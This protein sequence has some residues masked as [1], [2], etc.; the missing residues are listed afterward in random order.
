MDFP[1]N[2]MQQGGSNP[3]SPFR[4]DPPATTMVL[5]PW[6]GDEPPTMDAILQAMAN[7]TGQ[8]LNVRVADESDAG[9]VWAC[10]VEIDGLP[11]PCAIWCD[12]SEELARATHEITGVQCDTLIAFETLLSVD[13]PLTNYINLVRLV[14]MTLPDSPVLHDTGSGYWLER[15]RILQD[16]MDVEREPS[17][18]ILWRIELEGGSVRTAGLQRCGREELVMFDVPEML[19]Q[20]AIE[21]ISDIAALSLELELPG[22]EGML[23]ISPDILVRFEPVTDDHGHTLVSVRDAVHEES[24]PCPRLALN[25]MN[26]GEIAVFRTT[27]RTRQTTKLAQTTWDQFIGAC[28]NDLH[29]EG[30]QFMVQ[31]PFEQVD[32][33]EALREHLWL[34]VVAVQD[35]AVEAKLAHRPRLVPGLD[36]G[37]TTMVA[38]DEV[39]NWTVHTED[40][41]IGPGDIDPEGEAA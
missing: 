27:R 10:Q 7:C 31:V 26:I 24:T 22:S 14:S 23:E 36:I 8:E 1:L 15:D 9:P 4:F 28:R 21:S 11:S 17:E 18:D 12:R 30:L 39:S 3:P 25:A 32:D 29:N 19:Q 5:G 13:D 16:F 40:G 2:L 35:D 33:D 38:R 41:P 20:T 37:W 6:P 34:Q